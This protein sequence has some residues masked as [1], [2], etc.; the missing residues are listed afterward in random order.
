MSSA[1][2]TSRKRL[3]HRPEKNVLFQH[4]NV[5]DSE[6]G[7]ILSDQDVLVTGNKISSISPSQKRDA[8]VVKQL[9]VIDASGKH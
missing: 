1:P 8:A 2:A 7:K 4:A 5:F 9:E 6:A 3:A